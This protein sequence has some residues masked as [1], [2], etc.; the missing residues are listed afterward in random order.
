MNRMLAIVFFGL[1]A[2]S[3]ALIVAT[4]AELPLR[5]ASH[6]ASGGRANGWQSRDSYVVWAVGFGVL[7]PCIVAIAVGW[8][9]RLFPRFI[10]LPHREYWL[11]PPQRAATLATLASFGY[12]VGALAALFALAVH[13]AVIDANAHAPP[14]LDEARFFTSMAVFAVALVVLIAVHWRRFRAPR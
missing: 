10:N 3:A 4:S 12:C 6:F 2:A 13:F 14:R 5:V 1:L 9:P 11:A 7:V 8:L